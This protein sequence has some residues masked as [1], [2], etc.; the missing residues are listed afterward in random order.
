MR[1]GDDGPVTALPT[2]YR[3]TTEAPTGTDADVDSGDGVLGR[4]LG[5]LGAELELTSSLIEE[6]PALFS[7]A[8]TTASE[9]RS[10]AFSSYQ[11][12]RSRLNTSP[13]EMARSFS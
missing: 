4:Y 5:L 9:V 2:A 13:G 1:T 7:A 12:W 3:A 8:V 10:M 11:S 6:L